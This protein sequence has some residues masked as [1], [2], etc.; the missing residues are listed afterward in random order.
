MAG[1]PATE[2]A[3]FRSAKLSEKHVFQSKGWRPLNPVWD[4]GRSP[5]KKKQNALSLSKAE[6]KREKFSELL[7]QLR[8]TPPP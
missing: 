6:R 2:K 8:Y 3:V 4:R 1:V 5:S 7:R